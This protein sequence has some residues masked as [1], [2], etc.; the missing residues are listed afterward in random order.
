MTLEA[1]VKPHDLSDQPVFY[2]SAWGNLGYSLGTGIFNTAK[3]EGFIGEG[4]GKYEDVVSPEAIEENVWS[5]LALTYDGANMRLYVNGELVATQAQSTPPPT[6]EGPLA[7]GCNPLYP[8]DFDGLIDE[9]RIYNRALGAGEVAADMGA[10][11]QTPSRSPVAAYSFDAGEG[12]VA[13][14]LFG[15]HDGTIEGATWFDNGRYGKALSFDGADDCVTVADSPELQLTEEFTLQAWV[16]PQGEVKSDP[17]IFKETEGFFSYFLGL[18]LASSGKVEAYI[19]E[20][21]EDHTLVVSPQPLAAHVWAHVALTYDGAHMRLYLNGGLVDI[22]ATGIGNMPSSGPLQVGC[23]DVFNEHFQGLIDEPRIYNRALGAGEVAADMGSGLQAPF[24]APVA[25]YYFDAGEGQIAE[26]FFGEHDGTIEGATWFDNG[27]YGKALSFDGADDCVTVADSPELQLTEEFTL[28][29]WVKPRG[30]GNDEPIL[31]KE[32]SPGWG[33][34]AIYFGLDDQGNMEGLISDEGEFERTVTVTAQVMNVWTHV[35]LTYDGAHMRLYVDGALADTTAVPGVEPTNGPLSIGCSDEFDDYFNGMID[36]VRIY[37]RALRAGEVADATPPR[38]WQPLEISAIKLFEQS[39][40]MVLLPGASDPP[41]ANGVP[42]SGIA[43]Q[44]YRY[45]IDGGPFTPWVTTNTYHFALSEASEGQDLT[46]EVYTTDKADNKSEIESGS[47]TIPEEDLLSEDESLDYLDED[48][49]A[50]SGQ[51]SAEL[52]PE[53]PFFLAAAG[54]VTCRYVFDNPH[55]SRHPKG[56]GRINADMRLET[57]DVP[58]AAG[59]RSVLLREGQIVADSGRLNVWLPTRKARAT[60]KANVKC[61]KG[62]Y[63]SVGSWVV[64][65]PPN[66]VPNPSYKMK[67]SRPVMLSC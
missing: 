22:T 64:G 8:E 59:I 19:G 29:A 11:L 10:G 4:P 36:E 6:G 63:H 41:L 45:S 27:R 53:E 52:S 13:E 66:F 51:I 34:Y 60:A 28:Q 50:E 48:P 24:H 12:T 17:I 37:N 5:H 18:G 16:K 7:L 47:A 56:R 57:C 65:W 42:G 49:A 31:F 40:V 25:A 30:D 26:D 23:A 54:R 3:P 55:N 58:V 46:V 15:E 62:I 14:D 35:A 9:V 44:T 21:E 20:E 39:D 1:W 32:N 43:S 33:G 67:V 61:K 38:F 2:K